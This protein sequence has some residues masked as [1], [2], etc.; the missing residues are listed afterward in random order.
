[1]QL[2]MIIAMIDEDF[3]RQT[4]EP[5]REWL[6]KSYKTCGLFAAHRVVTIISINLHMTE[7]S[8]PAQSGSCELE[9]PKRP[10]QHSAL[11]PPD[12]L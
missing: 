6:Q 4:L 1:M 8:M 11:E 2:V 7:S 5:A 12:F 3:K 10:I 9:T